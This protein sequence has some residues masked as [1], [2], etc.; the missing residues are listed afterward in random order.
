MSHIP[1][2]IGNLLEDNKQEIANHPA[3]V[4]AQIDTFLN[5][6]EPSTDDVRENPEDI[7]VTG[8]R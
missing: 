6:T 3:S 7:D 1:T 5:F 2:C 8:L 4:T